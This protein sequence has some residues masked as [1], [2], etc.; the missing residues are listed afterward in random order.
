[1]KPNQNGMDTRVINEFRGKE[2]NRMFRCNSRLVV[3]T[4]YRGA[5]IA[6]RLQNLMMR[7]S[8]ARVVEF[9]SSMSKFNPFAERAGIKFG[10]PKRSQHYERGLAWF[11]RWFES[12]PTDK[13]AILEELNSWPKPIRDKCITEMRAI[14]FSVSAM[15]KSG[16]NRMNGTSRVDKMPEVKLLEQ[17]Q[18]VIFATPLYGI[19]M[20]PDFGRELPTSIPLLAFDNQ[21]PDEPLDLDKL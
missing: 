17:L 18:Q 14:Y 8:G 7:M 5:G 9:Q 3:D 10:K 19:Y 21:A 6:Y 12:H 13:V 2:M 4:T 16:D 15:E 1:M 20:N 11:R